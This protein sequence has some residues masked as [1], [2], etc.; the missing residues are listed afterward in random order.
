MFNLFEIYR[1]HKRY[2][3]LR[4]TASSNLEDLHHLIGTR[5]K[6]LNDGDNV[7]HQKYCISSYQMSITSIEFLFTL[8][9][10]PPIFRSSLNEKN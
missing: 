6:L 5:M 10:C 7:E 1:N 2:L 4:K 8:S 3:A 9:N